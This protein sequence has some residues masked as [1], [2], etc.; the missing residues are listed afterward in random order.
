[1]FMFRVLDKT[2]WTFKYGWTEDRSPMTPRE[3]LTS[4]LNYFEH[5]ET[6]GFPPTQLHVSGPALQ[7][8]RVH[9]EGIPFCHPITIYQ[10]EMMEFI[11]QSLLV[12]LTAGSWGVIK[13]P[14]STVEESP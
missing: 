2:G 9:F 13:D 10:G 12:N 8:L 7:F 1:M 3:M 4:L 6:C 5:R 14:E 11:I